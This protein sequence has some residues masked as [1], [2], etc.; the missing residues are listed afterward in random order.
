VRLIWTHRTM[1]VGVVTYD[2]SEQDEV[3]ETFTELLR[4]VTQDGG[5]KRAKGDKV[6]WKVDPGH[7]AGLFSHLAKWKAGKLID[8]DS[9]THP[10]VHAAWR[11]LAIAYQDM[12]IPRATKELLSKNDEELQLILGPAL[13][14]V[15]GNQVGTPTDQAEHESEDV[16]TRALRFLQAGDLPPV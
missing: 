15:S 11:C 7:E 3:L 12:V 13:A 5:R 6:S 14:R 10:L 4:A 2:P 1:G 8:E 9:G 16:V